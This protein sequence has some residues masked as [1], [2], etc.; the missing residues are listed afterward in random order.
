MAEA[1]TAAAALATKAAELQSLATMVSVN[2]EANTLFL[3]NGSDSDASSASALFVVDSVEV[4]VDVAPPLPCVPVCRGTATCVVGTCVCPEHGFAYEG[5]S[6]EDL[7]GSGV[8]ENSTNT[9]TRPAGCY[10]SISPPPSPPPP[11]YPPP[12][13]P[14]PATVTV[15]GRSF[16]SSP[17][18]STYAPLRDIYQCFIDKTALIELKRERLES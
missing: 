8:V 5:S 4:K 16:Q 6:I 9:T 15:D 2:A 14:P 17:N 7:L 13:S 12:P 11:P 18:S 1:A 3:G 10:S